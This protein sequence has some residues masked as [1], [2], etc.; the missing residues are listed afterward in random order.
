MSEKIERVA[1]AQAGVRW[2]SFDEEH[3]A[4]AREL[5]RLAIEAMRE[6]TDA[7][8]SAAWDRTDPLQGG[9]DLYRVMWDAMID[10]ALK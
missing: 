3:R 8:V 10:E 6:P 1:K 7:M 2:S 9:D 5:A 4:A